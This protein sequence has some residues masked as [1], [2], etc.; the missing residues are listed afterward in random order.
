MTAPGLA[1]LADDHEDDKSA[2]LFTFGSFTRVLAIRHPIRDTSSSFKACADLG[3]SSADVIGNEC[4]AAVGN[5]TDP[6]KWN[7][8]PQ[9]AKKARD[10]ICG[11]RDCLVNKNLYPTALPSDLITPVPAMSTAYCSPADGMTNTKTID[12]WIDGAT[13]GADMRLEPLTV[14]VTVTT[15]PSSAGPQPHPVTGSD[16]AMQTDIDESVFDSLFGPATMGTSPNTSAM[17]TTGEA[18]S[19]TNRATSRTGAA[20]A[21]SANPTSKAGDGAAP[22]LSFHV[23]ASLLLLTVRL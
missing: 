9:N 6:D 8:S 19:S 2:C 20:P 1:D 12:G 3:C 21:G 10:C 14:I 23:L 4:F 17:T 7:D 13:F 22:R 15:A 18:S 16:D 5:I 11:C